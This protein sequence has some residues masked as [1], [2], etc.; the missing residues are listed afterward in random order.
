M[1]VEPVLAIS[2][3]DP[4]G[5]GPEIV[6]QT[7][8]HASRVG[9]PVV[10]GHWPTVRAALEQTAPR[11]EVDVRDAPIPPAPGRATF[12]H[13]GPDGPPITSPGRSAA[14]AQMAALER[15]ISAV[16][17]GP[18]QALVTAP[19]NKALASSVEPSFAGHTEFLARRAGID[20]AAVTM[21]FTD[22]R[23]AIG[24][25]ATHVAVA[26]IAATITPARYER[27]I[28]HLIA[29]STA[30]GER[31][32]P[33]IAVA[34]VNPHAGEEGRFGTEERDVIEPLCRALT[35]RLE[36]QLFGPLPADTVYRDA[37]AGRYDAVVAAYHD[38]AMIPLKLGGLG[39]SVNVTMGLP[40]VRTSPDHGVAYEIARS[41]QAD[42]RGFQLAL[43]I[44]AALWKKT[45]AEE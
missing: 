34:A 28:R 19:M 6:A 18:C 26:E 35:G 24:L 11:V 1:P 33:R 3:G 8:E 12:V 30:L 5:I 21:V 44:A 23:L 10:V 9:R 32:T 38:Q 39:R 14:E 15:A 29:I 16:N 2:V 20:P 13:A 25:V 40:F 42:S 31:A 27:T 36:A 17:E 43:D 7:L 4:A 45:H 22:G 37:F 41:G